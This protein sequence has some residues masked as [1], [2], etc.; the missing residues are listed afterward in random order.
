MSTI[1]QLKKKHGNNG[2]YIMMSRRILLSCFIIMLMFNRYHYGF[3]H[4][5]FHSRAYLHHTTFAAADISISS[6]V[7]SFDKRVRRVFCFNKFDRSIPKLNRFKGHLAKLM[8]ISI[9]MIIKWLNQKFYHLN[10]DLGPFIF[11][12]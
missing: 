1:M 11:L 4:L 5:V 8:P 9:L 6:D 12:Q 7:F 3:W 10:I 2:A